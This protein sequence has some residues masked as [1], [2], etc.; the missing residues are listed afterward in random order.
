MKKKFFEAL[1]LEIILLNE[2]DV[3]RTSGEEF[4]G[5]IDFT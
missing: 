5:P 4:D 3:I 1:E 2:E